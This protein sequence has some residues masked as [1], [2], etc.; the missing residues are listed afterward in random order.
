MKCETGAVEVAGS[1]TKWRNLVM[2]LRS[3]ADT[4]GFILVFRQPRRL[5]DEMC[6]W[7]QADGMVHHFQAV[8]EGEE[9]PWFGILIDGWSCMVENLGEEA[10]G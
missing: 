7:K 10:R 8:L 5:G 9:Y 6:G 4:D 3:F 1:F 2:V